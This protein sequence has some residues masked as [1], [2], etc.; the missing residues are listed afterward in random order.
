MGF[1]SRHTGSDPGFT[2]LS[3]LRRSWIP[4]RD[5][6]APGK[7][8]ALAFAGM[9][10]GWAS[11]AA[12]Q[13]VA[14]PDYTRDSSWLCLP[15]RKD[16]CSTPLP[17]TALNSNGYGSNGPSAVAK[18]PPI[19]C[20]YV[21]PTVSSDPGMNSDMVAGRE[22]QLTAETQFARFAS[23]CRTFAP[24]YRQM[25][26]ASVVAY[27]AGAD[28]TPYAVIAYRDVLAAW[29]NYIRTRNQ[30]RP[31]VLIGH[32]QGSLLLGQLIAREIERDPA[33]ARRMQVAIIPGYNVLV[34]QGKLV[35]GTFKSMPL[36]SREGQTQCVMS[37]TSFRER[38]APPAGAIFGYADQAGM[39]VG[40]V[41]PAH[42]GSRNWEKLDS[43]WFARSTLPVPGGPI[44]WST[45]GPPPTPYVRTEGLVSAR[46]VNDGPRGYLS[47]RTNADPKDKRT[48]RIGGEVGL[49]GMFLPGWGMHHADIAETQ[50]DLIRQVED[51]ATAEAK[52][53]SRT[54]A[55]R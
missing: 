13:P 55:R 43:Y 30:G 17:T 20:F 22:E 5:R 52:A 47:V 44:Q 28:I 16:V 54:A 39:T 21:Y 6:L 42:P 10:M 12:P 9:T 32:S 29:R 53:R 45:E 15:G 11:P 27:A 8:A 40:C 1:L 46:C 19:D 48:D 51:I 41:N 3:L 4:A 35:G 38:N 18:D 33:V 49:L 50:G 7:A 34:P 36:C 23:V 26:T 2:L 25:T 14:A 31:F 24:V 37:W